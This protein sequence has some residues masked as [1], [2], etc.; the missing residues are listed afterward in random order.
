MFIDYACLTAIDSSDRYLM[1]P[2]N[3]LLL[4][5]LHSHDICFEL[6]KSRER[7]SSV[8]STHLSSRHRSTSSPPIQSHSPPPLPST[9]S[10]SNLELGVVR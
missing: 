8:H 7:Y 3:I 5:L 4:L 9:S 6:M 2:D 10:P 1:D